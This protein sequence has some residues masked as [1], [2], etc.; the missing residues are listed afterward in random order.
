MNFRVAFSFSVV[1]TEISST[2]LVSADED[3]GLLLSLLKE[4]LSDAKVPVTTAW[5]CMYKFK[6]PY[7]FLL[8]KRQAGNALPRS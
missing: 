4:I 1:S 2:V 8:I 7:Q 6:Y 3:F 5:V